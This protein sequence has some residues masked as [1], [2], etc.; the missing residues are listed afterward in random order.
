[1]TSIFH[2]DFSTGSIGI[3]ES[4]CRSFSRFL[5]AAAGVGVANTTSGP[6]ALR[7]RNTDGEFVRQGK[8]FRFSATASPTLFA[9]FPGFGLASRIR[10]S[11][12]PTSAGITRRRRT[13]RRNM[14]GLSL[15][16]GRRFSC[17]AM[18]PKP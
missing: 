7:N 11:L 8:R 9:F 16:R 2:G 18:R 17:E 15:R 4:T 5:E 13:C 12:S 10:H 3:P 6:F 14:P 1:M